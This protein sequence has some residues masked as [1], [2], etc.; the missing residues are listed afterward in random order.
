MFARR[1]AA[2]IVAACAVLPVSAC[3][4]VTGADS[5]GSAN[6]AETWTAPASGETDPSAGSE[7][8]AS[9]DPNA[10]GESSG[11]DE[12]GDT[13]ASDVRLARCL[14]ENFWV[15]QFQASGGTY[16]PVRDFVPYNGTD[17]PTCGGEPSVPNNAFYCSDGHFIA[18]DA[19]WLQGLYQQLG[20]AAVYVVI[21]HEFGHA[22]QAQLVQNFNFSKERELQAD[23][24]AGGTLGALIQA[25][26]LKADPG[27]DSE[28]MNN[29]IAAGDPTDAWWEPG[30]HGTAEQRI[31]AF[32]NGY[33]QG[34][35]AC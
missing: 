8:G 17:G 31:S 32:V 12:A 25:Q 22:V 6:R 35:S 9:S 21:P 34:V 16:E 24:Y 18:F 29:L 23:C 27:D 26:Q 20:D 13:F 5:P 14:T 10:A 30:A 1:V 19:N 28:V 4:A 3:G 7:S 11:C 2:V 33:Q 15:R